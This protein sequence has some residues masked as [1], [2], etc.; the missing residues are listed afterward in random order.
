MMD[1]NEFAVLKLFV[2]GILGE[3]GSITPFL[4]F[5]EHM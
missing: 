4:S 3:Y 2:V 5:A 1:T